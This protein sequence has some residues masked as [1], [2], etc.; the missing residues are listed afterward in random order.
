MGLV[1]LVAFF[2]VTLTQ[3]YRIC[4]TLPDPNLRS[5]SALMY[6]IILFNFI[7]TFGTSILQANYIF[8]SACGL[9]FALPRIAIAERKVLADAVIADDMGASTGNRARR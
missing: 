1:C 3:G 9:L 5:V 4:R 2:G 7:S 8:W 6:V